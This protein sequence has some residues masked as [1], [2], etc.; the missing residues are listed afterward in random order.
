MLLNKEY[1]NF[2]EKTDGIDPDFPGVDFSGK[3]KAVNGENKAKV[4][5][6][7]SEDDNSSDKPII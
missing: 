2:L 1:T 5:G 6:D 4:T 7:S 3:G